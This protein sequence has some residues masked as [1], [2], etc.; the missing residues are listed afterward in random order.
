MKKKLKKMSAVLCS[1]V[2]LLPDGRILVQ[3][4][5]QPMAKLLH[6]LN[7]RDDTIAAR[8][9]KNEKSL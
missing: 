5:T 3:N 9:H 4:L 8:V 2:L 7:P 1:D 6:S